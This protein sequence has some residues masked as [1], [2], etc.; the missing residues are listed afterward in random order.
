MMT[1]PPQIIGGKRNGSDVKGAALGGVMMIF[2]HRVMMVARGRILG[3]AIDVGMKRKKARNE[4]DVLDRLPLLK[5]PLTKLS[6]GN[7]GESGNST[8]TRVAV[9]MMNP[10]ESTKNTKRAIDLRS[11]ASG[12]G[13]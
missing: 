3:I 4:Q 7:E 10:Q 1:L 12:H 2:Y 8:A 5:L 13:Q 9:V 11:E 6:T